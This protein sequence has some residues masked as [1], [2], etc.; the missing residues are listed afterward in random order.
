MHWKE[1]LEALKSATKQLKELE[2]DGEDQTSMLTETRVAENPAEF[3][4]KVHQRYL[5]IYIYL[6]IYSSIF[7]YFH[8]FIVFYISHLY[9]FFHL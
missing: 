4:G 7:R 8:C 5:F 6:S 9:V 1:A 3:F 2:G